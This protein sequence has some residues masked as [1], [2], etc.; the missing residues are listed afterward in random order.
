MEGRRVD[1]SQG[2]SRTRRL[3][4]EPSGSS[5][6]SARGMSIVKVARDVARRTL[7]GFIDLIEDIMHPLVACIIKQYP[8]ASIMIVHQ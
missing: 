4:R 7:L 1:G 3:Q 8:A 5:T 6:L 2:L